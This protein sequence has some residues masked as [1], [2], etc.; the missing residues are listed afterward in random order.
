[1]GDEL[2]QSVYQLSALN[3]QL[4]ESHR[5]FANLFGANTHC[6]F[7][8]ENENLA[9][10]DFAGFGGANDLADRF[11]DHVISQDDLDLHFGQKIDRILAAAIDLGMAFLPSEPFYFGDRHS[12]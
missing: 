5:F 12:L 8:W 2:R 10:A 1:M 9:V 7:Y 6:V 3:Y 4:F 11:L